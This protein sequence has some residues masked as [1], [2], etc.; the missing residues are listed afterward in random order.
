M[1]GKITLYYIEISIQISELDSSPKL[2]S[3]DESKVGTAAL[4]NYSLP[5]ETVKTIHA[6]IPPA[7]RDI[8][9]DFNKK[10]YGR[11]CK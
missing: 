11:A 3:Y 9:N 8:R 6:I 5:N 2:C 10:R 7:K 4:E 1:S